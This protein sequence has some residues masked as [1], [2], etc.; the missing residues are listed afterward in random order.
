[1]YIPCALMKSK[2]NSANRL[3]LFPYRRRP[4][5]PKKQHPKKLIVKD[6]KR[7][8]NKVIEE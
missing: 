8:Q 7:Q 3:F 6:N 4:K 2:N 1:M 5:E